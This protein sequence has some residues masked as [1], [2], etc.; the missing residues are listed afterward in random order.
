[1]ALLESLGR[2][3][4]RG[5][6]IAAESVDD[7][8]HAE[9]AL[10]ADLECEADR[11]LVAGRHADRLGFAFAA[12]YQAALRA[13][14]GG[15]ATNAMS[16][17]AT[18]EG[19]AHPRAIRTSLTATGDAFVL[20][21]EKIWTTLADQAEQI[22]VFARTG[23]VDGRPALRAVIIPTSRE[24]VTIS[25]MPAPPFAPEV[26]HAR[27]TLTSV[28]VA[29]E[30][31]L[32]GDGYARYLKPFRTV[33]D[34]HVVCAAIGYLVGLAI[35]TDARPLA[36]RLIATAVAARACATM[37]PSAAEVH[38]VLGGVFGDLAAL[39]PE[40]LAAVERAPA[41]KRERYER[42]EAL[43]RVA[44]K[45]RAERLARAWE[46]ALGGSRS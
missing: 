44:S 35:E 18:E 28:R 4:T 39:R 24:G 14:L 31:L 43:M 30:D 15:R 40:I 20:D 13:L 29:A 27:V 32:E 41:A 46:R 36:E 17:A 9:R 5:T 25:A 22:M 42:D 26:A 23:E 12:G 2:L 3:L 10:T 34:A 16:L 21:G 33:E 19:G 6:P 1:M 11:A 37:D 45:A 7:F 38:V 8:L